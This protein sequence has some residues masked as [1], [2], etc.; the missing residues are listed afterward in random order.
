MK[1]HRKRL[2]QDRIRAEKKA[3]AAGW[4]ELPHTLKTVRSEMVRQTLAGNDQT[5]G[6]CAVAWLL[7]ADDDSLRWTATRHPTLLADLDTLLAKNRH[8]NQSCPMPAEELENLCKSIY[9]L[10]KT[11]TEA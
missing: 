3:V 11:I 6:A 1:K 2:E 9:N 7:N 10:V 5:L 8:G 4:K